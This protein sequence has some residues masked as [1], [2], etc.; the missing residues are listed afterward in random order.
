MVDNTDAE[1]RL[2][3]TDGLYLAGEEKAT[4]IMDI[5]T[6][7][8]AVRAR[9]GDEHRRDH[10]QQPQLI[11]RI[12]QSGQNH[13][14][15]FWELPLPEEYRELLKTPCADLNNVG[16]P[17]RAPSRPAC[18]CRSSFPRAR[19]GRISTSPGPSLWTRT[20][21]TT[22]PAPSASVSRRSWIWPRSFNDYF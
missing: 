8:G 14:E 20:G 10:G 4:H 12:I 2:V 7:T 11:Q 21:S 15:G 9:A 13:G 17:W 6:L 5:A 3:L 18:S 22:K 16:G 19:P 1:G